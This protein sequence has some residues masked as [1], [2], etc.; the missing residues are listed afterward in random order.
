MIYRYRETDAKEGSRET[1]Q[2]YRD[3]Q[4]H[5]WILEK[6]SNDETVG[7]IR[8]GNNLETND[9]VMDENYRLH[10]TPVSKK[11]KFFQKC[12]GYLSCISDNGQK[13]NI[14]VYQYSW[15]KI[16]ALLMGTLLIC[17][18]LLWGAIRWY[19]ST[20]PT[21][22]KD[23]IVIVQMPDSFENVEQ[24]SYS[25]PDYT[26]LRWNLKNPQT[27]TWLFNV[28]GNPYDISYKITLEDGRVLYESQ[29]LKPGESITGF[30]PYYLLSE[31]RYKYTM[32][33]YLHDQEN[34]DIVNTQE[35]EGVLEVYDEA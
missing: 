17:G 15:K 1:H 29:I 27:V 31:G 2:I 18:G 28:E 7:E 22:T 10:I 4:G 21:I 25:I 35:M 24:G 14:V 3:R 13:C 12:K 8:P 6:K 9:Y 30:T 20:L 23:D 19:H 33:C 5:E 11:R 32:E 34:G 26:E 16:M